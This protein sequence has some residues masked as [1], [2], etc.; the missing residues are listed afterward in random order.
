MEGRGLVP[1]T[2]QLSRFWIQAD[3]TQGKWAL[4]YPVL[5]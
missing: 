2:L 5:D 3:G 4:D 1:P